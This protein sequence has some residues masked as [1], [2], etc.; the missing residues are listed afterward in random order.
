[1]VQMPPANRQ[2]MEQLDDT[3]VTINV[4]NKRIKVQVEVLNY[5][6]QQDYDY[7]VCFWDTGSIDQKHQEDVFKEMRRWLTKE[8][9]HERWHKGMGVKAPVRQKVYM[10]LG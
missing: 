7:E 9:I 4:D 3:A 1:M 10:W 2:L 5:E 6:G 8:E